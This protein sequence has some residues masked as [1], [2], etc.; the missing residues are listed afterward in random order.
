MAPL[1]ENGA[2]ALVKSYADHFA[3]AK[4][5]ENVNALAD[6]TFTYL[7]KKFCDSLKDMAPAVEY[8]VAVAELPKDKPVS[9][10]EA[11]SCLTL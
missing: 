5:K 7:G 6:E 8:L 3:R 11:A 1:G 4:G 2:V 10:E 9:P